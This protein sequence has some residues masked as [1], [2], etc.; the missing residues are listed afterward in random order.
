MGG[1]D[2]KMYIIMNIERAGR[3]FQTGNKKHDIV[4]V[5]EVHQG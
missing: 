1:S 4:N 5:K 3:E 2:G